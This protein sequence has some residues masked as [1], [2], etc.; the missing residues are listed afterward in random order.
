MSCC[1]RSTFRYALGSN[2]TARNPNA[3]ATMPPATP[4]PECL[5]GK[6][7]ENIWLNYASILTKSNSSHQNTL[8]NSPNMALS[9]EVPFVVTNIIPAAMVS[10]GLHAD[11]NLSAERYTQ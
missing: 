11:C 4:G 9:S 6:P 8:N 10:S 7:N 1:N 3:K 2:S 5:I